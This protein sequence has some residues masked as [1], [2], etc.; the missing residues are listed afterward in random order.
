MI[1]RRILVVRLG[2]MGDIIHTLPAVATLKH[3]NPAAHVA[4]VVD[5]R[6]LCLLENNP[7]VDEVIPFDRRKIRNLIALRKRLRAN[8]FDTVFDFQGLIKS[9]LIASL[10]RPDHIHGFHQSQLRERLAGLF[11]SHSVLAPSSHV[12]D[13]NID[14]AASAGASNKLLAFPMPAG[15]PEGVLPD[16]PFV[17]ASPL[18]GWKAKQW[19]LEYYADLARLLAA[20]TGL[21]LVLN[22]PPSAAPLLASVPGVIH[23]VSGVAGL[24]YATRQAL[25][26]V[27][28]DSGPLH[29]AAALNKPGVAIFGPTGPERNGPYGSSIAV[30]RHPEARTSYKR[31]DEIDPSIRRITPDQVLTVLEARIGRPLRYSA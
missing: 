10:A 6:W 20:S 15:A 16:T 5:P 31:R 29:L 13:R 8:R 14:L 3:S 11:Y 1:G 17:L 28:I 18:G 27:G 24:V 4:W 12:V 25:A 22:G 19:P 21:P 2:S 30:L 7:F 26:V 23:H 9:A